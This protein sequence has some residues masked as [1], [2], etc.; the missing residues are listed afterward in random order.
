MEGFAY[1]VKIL[2][3]RVLLVQETPS[4]ATDADFV[5]R[6]VDLYHEAAGHC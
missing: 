3:L 2:H 4:S 5:V 6:L 1:T